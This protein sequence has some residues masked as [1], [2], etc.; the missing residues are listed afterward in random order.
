MSQLHPFSTPGPI[1]LQ[2]HE[3][4]QWVAS[5][6]SKH[7]WDTVRRTWLKDEHRNLD[8]TL[9]IMRSSPPLGMAIGHS[10]LII[11]WV[12]ARF[13]FRASFWQL[14][15]SIEKRNTYKFDVANTC[16]GW[17][18][19]TLTRKLSTEI[20]GCGSKSLTWKLMLEITESVPKTGTLFDPYPFEVTFWR[21]V[22]YNTN[23][24]SPVTHLPWLPR[25][26]T[27]RSLRA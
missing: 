7:V 17:K 6:A 9:D 22:L 21:K 4:P 5:G 25:Q 12:V 2:P 3:H 10:Q 20:F 8:P 19:L 24:H 15:F 18:T 26:V 1:V 14:I 23:C 13:H 27:T 11:L 16:F